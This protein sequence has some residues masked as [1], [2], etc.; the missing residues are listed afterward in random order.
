MTK[1]RTRIAPS[2]TGDMHIGNFRTALY[3]Y[4]WAK[5]NNGE[6]I[7]RLEDTDRKRYIEG[8]AQGIFDL[9]DA[10][11]IKIDHR[12]TPNQLAKLN[13]IDY[14][15]QDW[16]L[17]ETNY[18]K[19]NDKDFDD[20]FVQTQRL[21]LYLKYAH[22]LLKNG[23]AY[24]CFLTEGELKDL[25]E[26][27]TWEDDAFRSPHR[28]MTEEEILKRIETGENY[29][30]RLDVEG[31]KKIR[32]VKEIEYEDIVLGKMKF[33]LNDVED[34]I[35]IKSDGIP[36]Y[37]LAVVVDDYLMKVTHPMRG[38]GWIPSIPKQVM[39]YDA[40][41]WKMEPFCHLTDILDPAGGKL[42]K[43]KGAVFAIEFLKDGYLPD[44]MIN[45]LALLG[46]SP[47]IERK[48]GEKERE[49]FSEEE[50]I[51]LFDLEGISNVNPIFNREKLTWFNQQYIKVKSSDD[52][53]G[54]FINWLE[55]YA[56][57]KSLLTAVKGDNKLKN[58]LELFQ[59]RSKTLV[60]ILGGI[61]F[62][63]DVPKSIDWEV[64]QTKKF[65][66]RISDIRNQILNL[67]QD[68]SDDIGKWDQEKWVADMRAISEKFKIKGGDSFMVLRVAVCGCPFSPPLFETLQI[69]GKDEVISRLRN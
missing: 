22:Q 51:E 26:G 13:N 6:F 69:L 18:Q 49:I 20:V 15:P 56:E 3:C 46:W 27:R 65:R 23:F 35:I 25:R 16:Y 58:K 55:K 61:K 5:K 17:K 48:H 30:V 43:R 8:S 63:Y 47:S 66:D 1:I 53:A 45:F 41:G 24:L 32:G 64:K 42:S 4:F 31:F 54:I 38:Y 59:G 12:A 50:L 9:F 11:G 14:P 40:L 62:F 68:Y 67:L 2:P 7:L 60:E 28:N 19:I 39:I 33:N 37:H 36:T 29:V 57:D 34:Q 21:P 10:Y 44:A 52:L